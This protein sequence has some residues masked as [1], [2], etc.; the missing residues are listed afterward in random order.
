MQRN[1]YMEQITQWKEE[2]SKSEAQEEAMK[3]IKKME[4]IEKENCRF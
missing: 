3:L 2:A 1:R 4:L